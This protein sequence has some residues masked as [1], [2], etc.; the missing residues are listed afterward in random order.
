M[1]QIIGLATGVALGFGLCLRN[2]RMSGLKQLSLISSTTLAGHFAG[3]AP[4][5]H[6]HH[7]YLHDIENPD[8][9]KRAMENIQKN[10]PVRS[11]HA[12][13]MRYYQI[14]PDDASP[15][16]APGLGMITFQ[17]LDILKRLQLTFP[18]N[19]LRH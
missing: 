5:V 10:L 9:Y 14:S 1:P 3:M 19:H 13:L 17:G 8:G 18:P 6:V 15:Q 11:G 16:P 2:P 12:I 7:V 4:R